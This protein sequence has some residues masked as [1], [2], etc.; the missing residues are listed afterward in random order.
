MA[1]R[2]KKFIRSLYQR[3]WVDGKDISSQELL[4]DV[5]EW[6][7]FPPSQICG[8]TA[9]PID[10]RLC[11]WEAQWNET[12]HSGVPLLQRSDGAQLVGLVSA[13]SLGRFFTKGSRL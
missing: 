5:A 9:L 3:Y 7:G 6:H 8:K 12:E 13:S 10:D 4:R 2:L 11:A 1:Y